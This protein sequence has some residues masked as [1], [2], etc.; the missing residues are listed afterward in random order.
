MQTDRRRFVSLKYTR[1]VGYNFFARAF[2]FE[3]IDREN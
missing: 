1:N 2:V 3:E